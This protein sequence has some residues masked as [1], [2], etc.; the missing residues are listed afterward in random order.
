ML[1]HAPTKAPI[2]SI[3]HIGMSKSYGACWNMR[4]EQI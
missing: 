3:K 4:R 2:H 1:Q